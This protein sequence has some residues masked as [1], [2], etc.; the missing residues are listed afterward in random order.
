MKSCL[1]ARANVDRDMKAAI[2][3]NVNVILI[4]ACFICLLL[5]A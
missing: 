4:A 2:T 3:A 5:S 1:P